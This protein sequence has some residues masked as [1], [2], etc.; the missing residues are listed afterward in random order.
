M[1]AS[2]RADN[3]DLQFEFSRPLSVS[4]TAVAV[5]MS[6][7]C[8]K[9][10]ERVVYDF[11]VTEPAV[12]AI[13]DL[14]S[15]GIV[16]ELTESA[17]NV[18]RRGNLLSFS[19]GFDSLAAKA[20]M[21][22][23]TNLVPMDFGGR[24]ARERSFFEKFDTVPVST[25]VTETPLRANSWSFMG[26][27]AIL[28]SDYFRSEYHTFGSILEAGPDNIK[29]APVAARNS[30][31]P[32]FR[33]MGYTNASYVLGLS[34]IGTLTVM[35]RTWPELVG[36]S[37]LSLA[38]PG[39]EKLYRKSVIARIV[40]D[41]I[42]IN[43]EIPSVPPLSRPHFQFGDNFAVDMLSLYVIAKTGDPNARN[44]VR[45]VPSRVLKEMS[46]LSM[47]FM[48]RANPVM[49]EKFPESLAPALSSRLSECGIKWYTENDWEELKRVRELLIK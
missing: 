28:V 1:Q 45:D 2:T 13:R 39:E 7:L 47:A 23:D 18:L 6:T 5:A 35:F 17:V 11:P 4:C 43:T 40:A 14:T 38:S 9:A 42:G 21:P 24:F 48:E 10:F 27:G 15:A 29:V 26:I 19:G 22:A 49:Y 32:P 44:L 33:A 20:L 12:A 16:V 31:F 46:G 34:E 3:Y 8:G 41:S 30:T 25:N 36:E 37:L